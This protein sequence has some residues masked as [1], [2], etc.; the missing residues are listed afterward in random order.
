MSSPIII[1]ALT[2]LLN[3]RDVEASMTLYV[4]ALGME[5]IASWGPEGGAPRWAHLKSG[6]VE[7]MLN[8]SDSSAEDGVARSR[9]S[10]SA[11]FSDSVLYFRVADANA[12]HDLL[13][14]RGFSV[15]EPFDTEY[16][17]REFHARDLDGYELAFVSKLGAG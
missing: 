4:G 9:R 6:G 7:L 13:K 10:G 15:G 12:L 5:V 17:L 2:P 3:V 11:S 8:V 14:K 1:E 16:G